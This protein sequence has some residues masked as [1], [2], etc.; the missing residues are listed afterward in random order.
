MKLCV[1]LDD[2]FAQ[3]PDGTTWAQTAFPKSFW[4]RYLTVFDH[5]RIGARAIQVPTVPHDW[6]QVTGENISFV[7]VPHYVGPLQYLQ[8]ANQVK[9]VLRRMIERQDAVILRVPSNLVNN[10]EPTLRQ[11]GHLYAVE[12]VGDPYGTF[13]PGAMDHPLRPFFRWWFMHRLRQQCLSACALAYV[14]QSTLQRRYPPAP[15][16][17]STHFSSVELPNEAFVVQPRPPLQDQ[18][19]CRIIFIGSMMHRYKAPD[20]LLEACTLCLQKGFDLSLTIIGDGKYRPMFE[21]QA[22]RLGVHENVQFIGQISTGNAV[23]MQLDQADLFVLPSKTEGL[24]RSMLE[25]M[26]RGLPCI[27]SNIGGIPE[28]LPPEAMVQP[29]DANALAQKI[30]EFISNPARL[31]QMAAQNLA[32]AKFYHEEILRERR[33]AFYR[34]VKEKTEMWLEERGKK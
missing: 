27:G 28:L 15:D 14:T 13:A 17:F 31:A 4:Q 12:V 9:R 23:R 20:V 26:A 21:A 2:H 30:S 6:L 5:V 8:Q 1:I 7:A 25:A 29:G 33:T 24:P 11:K 19:P 22:K 18:R 16:A 32:K 3:T 10:V 34:A